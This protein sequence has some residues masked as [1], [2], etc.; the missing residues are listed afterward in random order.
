MEIGVFTKIFE[1]DTFE[2]VMDAVK[3][4]GYAC[5]QLNWESA[6]LDPMPGR[7][8]D[9]VCDCIREAAASRGIGI[10]GVSGTYSMIHPDPAERADGMRRLNSS[11]KRWSDQSSTLSDSGTCT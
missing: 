7:L 1:R 3:A 4:Y 10:A 5:V 2:D 11:Q 6:G 9:E 8:E